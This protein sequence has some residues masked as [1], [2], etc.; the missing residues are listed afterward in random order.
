M[1]CQS[2]CSVPRWDGVTG[3]ATWGWGT[4]CWEDI[5]NKKTLKDWLQEWGGKKIHSPF[6][7]PGKNVWKPLHK[8]LLFSRAQ[9]LHIPDVKSPYLMQFVAVWNI[10]LLHQQ[11]ERTMKASKIITVILCEGCWFL[12]LIPH[13]QGFKEPERENIKGK[14]KRLKLLFLLLLTKYFLHWKSTQ[15]FKSTRS[16]FLIS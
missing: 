8:C 10:S 9:V 2:Q 11:F 15:C 13:K 6:L 12:A 14:R 5:S 7:L 4:D 16:S 1:R 3:N